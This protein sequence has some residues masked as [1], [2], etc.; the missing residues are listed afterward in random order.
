MIKCR[1][2]RSLF[3][4]LKVFPC[5]QSPL[6]IFPLF[7]PG[8]S[9]I[10]QFLWRC[11]VTLPNSLLPLLL[12]LSLPAS[13]LLLPRY[14]MWT[15][16]AMTVF[17]RISVFSIARS[18]FVFSTVSSIM[19]MSTSTKLAIS[20]AACSTCAGVLG[21]GKRALEVSSSILPSLTTC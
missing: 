7:S 3:F 1:P 2:S 6:L 9:P 19:V 15:G 8:K 18:S 4:T 10:V 16:S 17:S 5:P 20:R 21:I 11:P 12:L 13:S 14:A